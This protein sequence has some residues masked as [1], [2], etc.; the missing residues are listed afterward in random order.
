MSLNLSFS[1][2]TNIQ[3]QPPKYKPKKSTISNLAM[4]LTHTAIDSLPSFS[5]KLK[6][7]GRIKA[8]A[9]FALIVCDQVRLNR[10]NKVNSSLLPEIIPTALKKVPEG[11]QV[12]GVHGT[13]HR[14][15]TFPFDKYT[16]LY[17]APIE[18]HDSLGQ[19][20]KNADYCLFYSQGVGRLFLVCSKDEDVNSLK[21]LMRKNAVKEY[22]VPCDR[23]LNEGSDVRDRM[24]FVPVPIK[25]SFMTPWTFI[26]HLYQYSATQ[27]L[28]GNIIF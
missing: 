19:I 5:P 10:I 8:F 28:Q 25:Q 24:V 6:C 3:Y 4:N 27:M 14:E 18:K 11:Y 16:D 9:C 22:Y 26:R 17:L 2:I 7:P 21:S 13:R 1:Q 20:I 12:V 23:N 15:T